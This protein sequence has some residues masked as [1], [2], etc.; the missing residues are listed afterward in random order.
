[1]YILYFSKAFT[2]ISL[3]CINVTV[4]IFSYYMCN[5]NIKSAVLSKTVTLLALLIYNVIYVCSSLQ[6][7]L[8]HK[9]IVGCLVCM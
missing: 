2:C 9:A 1:M 6:P 3:L 7:S 4:E 5:I 8:L